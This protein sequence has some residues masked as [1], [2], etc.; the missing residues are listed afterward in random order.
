MSQ[1]KDKPFN[2]RF[3]K[4]GDM[5]EGVFKHWCRQNNITYVEYGMQRPPFDHFMR[6]S[7]FLRYTPDFLCEAQGERFDHLID[8]RGKI[9]RHFLTEIKGVGR[10]QIIKLK[11]DNVQQLCNWQTSS[12]RPVTVFVY[13]SKNEA[14][15]YRMTMDRLSE[16]LPDLEVDH[17]QDGGK[18]KPF[19]RLPTSLLEWEPFERTN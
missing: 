14:I 6:L 13:D 1:F 16:L 15:S 17:F 3:K 19:Y 9:T 7:P 10:D 11:L 2:V 5:A 8:E 4:M 12:G 18:P